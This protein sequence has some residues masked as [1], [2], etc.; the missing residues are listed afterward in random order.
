MFTLS[1]MFLK[2]LRKL[3]AA[4]SY[5]HFYGRNR[6][7]RCA[8]KASSMSIFHTMD[9]SAEL[10]KQLFVKEAVKLFEYPPPETR[11]DLA[12]QFFLRF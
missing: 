10:R 12:V 11:R 7:G 8:E 5:G 3:Q 9:P 4:L 2:Q 1:D 6:Y